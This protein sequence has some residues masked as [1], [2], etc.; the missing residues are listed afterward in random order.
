MVAL[1]QLRV[2]GYPP[3]A[4]NRAVARGQLH[5][6]HRGVYAVGHRRL[7]ARGRRMA[8]VLACGA[9]A[10]LS[11]RSAAALWDLGSP[12]AGPIEVTGGRT[13]R[14]VPGVRFHAARNLSA[15]DVT[16]HDGIPV[17]A[18]ER[19]LLDLAEVLG[20][21]RLRRALEAAERT[22]RLD[23]RALQATLERHSGARGIR[24]LRAAMSELRGS[25]P[26]TQSELENAFL[27]LIRDAGLPE[28][29]CNVLVQGELVDCF[30]PARPLVVELD[31]FRF[32][33][34]RR[35]FEA[36]RRRDVKLQLAGIPVLRFTHARIEQEP[37]QVLREVAGMLGE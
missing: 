29:H 13:R 37:R 34:T 18:V 23:W 27:A 30:W 19:T 10:V 15:E 32:H 1:W 28:P 3:S 21:Q 7:T 11:H 6:I 12:P 4:V 20:P 36:D 26:W 14:R 9:G 25:A 33:R 35:S 31:G 24:A 5:R 17:T 8:A 22:E 16:V 2:L